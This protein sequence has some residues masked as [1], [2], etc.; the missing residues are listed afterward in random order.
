[1]LVCLVLRA[2]TAVSIVC[3]VPAGAA[4]GVRLPALAKVETAITIP[5]VANTDTMVI[6]LPFNTDRPNFTKGLFGFKNFI[7]ILRIYIL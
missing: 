5:N 2:L 4:G 7:L 1:M 6:T 3:I